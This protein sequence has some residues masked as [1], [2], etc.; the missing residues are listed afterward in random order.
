M[1][2]TVSPS[3]YRTNLGAAERF[4]HRNPTFI[5]T[6]VWSHLKVPCVAKLRTFL[7]VCCISWLVWVNQVQLCCCRHSF[8]DEPNKFYLSRVIIAQ[9][10]QNIS[11]HL[12]SHVEKYLWIRTPSGGLSLTRWKWGVNRLFAVH[13]Q[14]MRSELRGRI[15]SYFF[16]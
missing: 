6:S 13:G 9:A 12:V 1:G 2:F 14:W 4:S 15:A 16:S 7:L 3:G 11:S 10:A 5:L 8:S